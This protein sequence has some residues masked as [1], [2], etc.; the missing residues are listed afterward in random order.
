M[1]KKYL[2]IIGGLLIFILTTI[3]VLSS[4]TS[5]RKKVGITNRNV[6]LN[7]ENP[8]IQSENMSINMANSKLTNQSV[9][10]NSSNINNQQVNINNSGSFSNQDTR[11]SNNNSEF[12]NNSSFNNQSTRYE[13]QQTESDPNYIKYQNQ[14]NE[15]RRIQDEINNPKPKDDYDKYVYQNINWNQWKSNFLNKILDDSMYIKSLDNYEVGSTFYYS[16]IVTSTGE[17]RNVKVQSFNLTTEDKIRVA[18]LIKNYAHTP[19]TKFPKNSRRATA[20]VESIVLLGPQEE[21][22]KP[23]DFNDIEHIK[24]KLP[25]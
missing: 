4:D 21:K 14:Q 13:N 8:E 22:A 7:N 6:V 9:D 16:F 19:I 17:I 25:H 3:L 15:L 20:K 23:S 11:F 1:D 2:Y 12:S 10:I 5:T 24:V 18:N